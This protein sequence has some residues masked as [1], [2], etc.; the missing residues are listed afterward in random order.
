MTRIIR[1]IIWAA[2]IA[3]IY[4]WWSSPSVKEAQHLP[5]WPLQLYSEIT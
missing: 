5:R 1:T 4:A 2:I 3:A